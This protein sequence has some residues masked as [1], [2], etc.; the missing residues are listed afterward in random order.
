MFSAKDVEYVAASCQAM[1]CSASTNASFR[2]RQHP[3]RTRRRGFFLGLAV[4]HSYIGESPEWMVFGKVPLK[5][6]RT[7]G[8][9]G[10][11]SLY[12]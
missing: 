1:W 10:K 2:G 9:P 12:P 8:S 6:M 5:W 3:R 4:V 7:G 11:E